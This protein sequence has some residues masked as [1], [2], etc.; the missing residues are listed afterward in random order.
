VNLAQIDLTRV[1]TAEHVQALRG[2]IVDDGWCVATTDEE[3]RVMRALKLPESVVRITIN[4][5]LSPADRVSAIGPAPLPIF[6]PP[7][8]DPTKDPADKYERHGSK[9]LPAPE[10]ANLEAV[11]VAEVTAVLDAPRTVSAEVRDMLIAAAARG[12]RLGPGVGIGI[13]VFPSDNLI[14]V[15][16]YPDVRTAY[17]AAMAAPACSPILL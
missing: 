17:R 12:Y 4:K 7:G 9:R 6:M 13:G 10:S 8:A 11:P 16:F 3:R 1:Q 15:G 2:A 14:A 5:I